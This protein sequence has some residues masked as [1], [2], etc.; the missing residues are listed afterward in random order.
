[1]EYYIFQE[2][3]AGSDKVEEKINGKWSDVVIVAESKEE[4]LNI[5]LKSRDLEE[6]REL[7]HAFS[8]D[9]Y[10]E[11]R[12]KLKEAGYSSWEDYYK[13]MYPDRPIEL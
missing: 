3:Q 11:N 4:A 13:D 2:N 6:D 10:D 5:Y 9:K 8:K 7:Y 12:R 1:M